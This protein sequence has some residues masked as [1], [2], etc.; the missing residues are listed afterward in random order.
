MQSGIVKWCVYISFV[1]AGFAASDRAADAQTT[2]SPSFNCALARSEVEHLICAL[3]SLQAKDNAMARQYAATLAQ[4]PDNV[5]AIKK[6][7]VAWLRRRDA[8]VGSTVGMADCVSRSYDTRMNE[9]GGSTAPPLEATAEPKSL[10]QADV[11]RLHDEIGQYAQSHGQTEGELE[12][13][14]GISP[15]DALAMVWV[16]EQHGGTANAT[17]GSLEALKA[18]LNDPEKVKLIECMGIKVYD[19]PQPRGHPPSIAEC[20][21][22]TQGIL[23]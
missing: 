8:C 19:D 11:R 7:Q 12:R 9:L 21:R 5:A 17:L 16:S 4:N 13:D 10:T 15:A 1:G 6:A 18:D 23:K 14:L 22:I 2:G 3:P 20:N